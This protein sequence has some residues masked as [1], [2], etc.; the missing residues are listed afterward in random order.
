MVESTKS[1]Y[2]AWANQERLNEDKSL[3][4]LGFE[5]RLYARKTNVAAVS[6]CNVGILG[7][8]GSLER[9]LIVQDLHSWILTIN[10]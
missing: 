4:T 9:E 5:A 2:Y 1:I 8:E 10:W 3:P 6:H 7:S